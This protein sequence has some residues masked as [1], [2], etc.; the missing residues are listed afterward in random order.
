[1]WS[2]L[3]VSVAL[4]LVALGAGVIPAAAGAA[5]APQAV[6]APCGEV[7]PDAM[8]GTVSVPLDRRAPLGAT[9][10]IAFRLYPHTD[11]SQPALDPIIASEGGPGY[12]ILQNNA[13][14]GYAGYAFAGLRDR[15]D[16]VMFDQ[17]GVGLS[18][19]IDCPSIQHGADDPPAAF[20]ACAALL[21]PTA[22]A[23]R[24]PRAARAAAGSE[25]SPRKGYPR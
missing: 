17:R 2:P 8:C 19:A 15:H 4:V 1:M 23:A 25:C 13:E 14:F 7:A 9:I 5:P 16:L 3:R 10:P 20:A 11:T 21:G 24:A 12:S 6:M 22:A 18:G